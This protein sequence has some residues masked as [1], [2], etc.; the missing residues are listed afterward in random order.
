MSTS[1]KLCVLVLCLALTSCGLFAIP[2]GSDG[3][4]VRAGYVAGR[5]YI[6]RERVPNP[7]N[8]IDILWYVGGLVAAAAGAGGLQYKKNRQLTKD[9]ESVKNGVK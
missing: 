3:S 9:I 1:C 2:D 6:E 8:P 5:E 7:G 4:A